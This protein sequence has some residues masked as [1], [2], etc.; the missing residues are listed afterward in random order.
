MHNK[1]PRLLFY[2]FLLLIGFSS[3]QKETP[4]LG[5]EIPI[6]DAGP[7]QIVQLPTDS[8]VLNGTGEDPDGRIIGYLWSQV[9]G[10]NTAVI[11]NNGAAS[12][13]VKGLVAGAYIFQLM[14]I[15]SA[16]ATATDTVLVTVKPPKVVTVTLQPTQNPD[17]IHIWGTNGLDGSQPFTE[18]GAAFWT[19]NGTPVGMRAAFKFD[20]SSIPAGATI[21]SAKLSLYSNPQ[22]KNGDLVHANAGGNNAMLIQQ[23][24]TPWT[25]ST[26]KWYNQ[27][28]T[29]TNNQVVIPGTTQ[30]FLDLIDVDV[31]SMVTSM[32]STKAN[33]GF[34]IR[35]QNEELYNSRIFCSSRYE[36]ATKHPKLVVVYQ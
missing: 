5:N 23:V 26:V 2:T 6:A 25:T 24:T 11:A 35:L 18:I 16:G 15:D 34:F 13:T 20:L 28:G 4:A 8:T 29:T 21:L 22:P 27:P 9:N 1:T 17:E 32:V 7:A 31:T 33:Y 12:T 14:A 10:P 19:Y 3:C 36:D 30:P